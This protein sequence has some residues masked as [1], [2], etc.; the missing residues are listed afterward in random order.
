MK[1]YFIDFMVGLVMGLPFLFL[2]ELISGGNI[3]VRFVSLNYYLLAIPIFLLY[4]SWF[5]LR[6]KYSEKFKIP[7]LLFSLLIFYLGF[8]VFLGLIYLILLQSVDS[9]MLL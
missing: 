9:W 3:G 7:H 6:R 8:F 1:K 4:K 2:P 5:L